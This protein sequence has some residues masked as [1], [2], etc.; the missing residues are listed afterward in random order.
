MKVHLN[1]L[2]FDLFIL[3]GKSGLHSKV[4]SMIYDLL[5]SHLLLFN[6]LQ[7]Y[8]LLSKHSSLQALVLNSCFEEATLCPL[9]FFVFERYRIN[10]SYI[11]LVEVTLSFLSLFIYMVNRIL[12]SLHTFMIILVEAHQR[13]LYIKCF[14]D[15]S[16][17]I[18]AWLSVVRSLN[19]YHR[20]LIG[21]IDRGL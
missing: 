12:H 17:L 15:F 14:R 6:L 18:K 2:I 21:L 8:Y 4:M 13:S 9:S 20:M 10:S 5:N 16:R 19:S 7:F 3:E 1:L 11:Y